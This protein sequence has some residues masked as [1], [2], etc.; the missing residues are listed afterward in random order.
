MDKCFQISIRDMLES[1]DEGRIIKILSSFSCNLNGEIEVFLK[2][3]AIPFSKQGIAQTHVVFSKASDGILIAGYYAL[4]PKN[5]SIEK[6]VHLSRKW[7]D[8]LKRFATY[9]KRFGA[10]TLS[11]PLI[12]QLGKNYAPG[13]NKLITG[14]DLLSLACEKV[15]DIQRA[16][17][18]KMVFVECEDVQPLVEFYERNGFFSFGRRLQDKSEIGTLKGKYL[19]QMI[20]YL[21]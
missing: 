2:Q 9:D 14:D 19:V 11:I 18:G 17:G 13:C 8:R 3:K 21:S 7:K 5:I 4:A 12:A 20:K 15:K 6:N 1:M 10:Y 16:I